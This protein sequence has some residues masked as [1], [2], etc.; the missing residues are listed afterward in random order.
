VLARL[1]E[2]TIAAGVELTP[3]PNR[4]LALAQRLR[5]SSKRT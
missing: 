1:S 2:L 4:I 5:E 3:L